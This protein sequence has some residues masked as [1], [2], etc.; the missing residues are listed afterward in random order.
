MK[1]SQIFPSKVCPF[2]GHNRFLFNLEMTNIRSRRV[3]RLQE[4]LRLY[5]YDNIHFDIF[6][7]A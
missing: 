1:N 4:I 6:Q 2:Q 7:V 3:K 5:Y